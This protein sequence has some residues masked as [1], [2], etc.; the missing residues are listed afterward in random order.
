MLKYKCRHPTDHTWR[1]QKRAHWDNNKFYPPHHNH[2]DHI[3]GGSWPRNGPKHPRY[4]EGGWV[5]TKTQPVHSGKKSLQEPRQHGCRPQDAHHK[6][7]QI[8]ISTRTAETIHGV[9][10][11]DG[12]TIGGGPDATLWRYQHLQHSEQKLTHLGCNQYHAANRRL[13]QEHWWHG[14]F[15]CR[16]KNIVYCWKYYKQGITP[17]WRQANTWTP[18]ESG[19]ARTRTKRCGPTSINFF[20]GIYWQT[21]EKQAHQKQVRVPQCTCCGGYLHGAWHTNHG[22]HRRLVHCYEIDN[23]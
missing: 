22:D 3:C 12:P 2:I 7:G 21:W 18:A 19:D 23:D 1:R 5:I 9:F 13:L 17:L 8:L 10:G 16:Q 15:F 11:C 14:G 20:T 4:G 6:H